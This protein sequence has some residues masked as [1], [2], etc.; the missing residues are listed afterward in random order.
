MPPSLPL[1]LPL[2]AR[3]QAEG[4]APSEGEHQQDETKLSQLT[5][6]ELDRQADGRFPHWNQLH[7]NL[8]LGVKG[9][10]DLSFALLS[11]QFRA[12]DGGGDGDDREHPD[13]GDEEGR[14]RVERGW[15]SGRRGR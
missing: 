2:T 13:A 1:E 12:Q 11:G 10:C 8:V 4:R 7:H 14:P 6:S 9:V 5:T 15:R 3:G